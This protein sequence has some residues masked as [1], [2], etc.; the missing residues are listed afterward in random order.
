MRLTKFDKRDGDKDQDQ[1]Q[2]RAV[3]SGGVSP[4]VSGRLIGFEMLA[5][6]LDLSE[7]TRGE[8]VAWWLGALG[9]GSR[10][11]TL[12][13]S[14]YYSCIKKSPEPAHIGSANGRK[15]SCSI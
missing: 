12:Q 11:T 14:R 8:D 2:N 3:G 6:E 7:V 5:Q 15:N 13:I 4:S 9:L 1:N 10:A